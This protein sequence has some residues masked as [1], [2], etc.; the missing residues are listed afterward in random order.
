MVDIYEEYSIYDSETD[1][2]V[3]YDRNATK[4]EP[5]PC[6][7]GTLEVGVF[8]IFSESEILD[9]L[10][11]RDFHEWAPD[12]GN[13]MFSGR[14]ISGV[15]HFVKN[16]VGWDKVWIIPYVIRD[17]NE[18]GDDFIHSFKLTP[19]GCRGLRREE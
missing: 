4:D 16:S 14:I 11:L 8:G 6:N 15:Y 17:N 9:L 3:D 2:W 5:L 12:T 1:T 18:E 7:W 13:S 19:E 10:D